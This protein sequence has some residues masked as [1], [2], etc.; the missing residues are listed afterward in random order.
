[1]AVGEHYGKTATVFAATWNGHTWSLTEAPEPR[2]PRVGGAFHMYGSGYLGSVS[3]VTHRW[4]MVVW[5]WETSPMKDGPNYGLAVTTSQVWNGS[6]FTDAPM[7]VPK[8]GQSVFY[9]L[10]SLSCATSSRCVA[11][12]SE[13]N[14]SQ[15]Y[16]PGLQFGLVESWNGSSWKVDPQSGR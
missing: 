1:M 2:F 7:P 16:F 4:C 6:T 11:I 15:R 9:G 3:C 12:G 14:L 10:R 13:T 5:T 8:P